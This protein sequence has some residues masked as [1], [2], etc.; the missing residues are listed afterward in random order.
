MTGEV[1]T[2]RV[3]FFAII[4]GTK[5]PVTGL[6]VSFDKATKRPPEHLESSQRAIK[7]H[8]DIPE[9]LFETFG[10]EVTVFVP[11]RPKVEV[12]GEGGSW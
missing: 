6:K 12:S 11:E 2:K 5:S 1:K 10:A 3:S 9:S 8:L 4:D 7:V